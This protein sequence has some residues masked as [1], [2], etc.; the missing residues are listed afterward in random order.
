MIHKRLNRARREVQS[1]SDG[2]DKKPG[3]NH[4]ETN[5]EMPQV[6]AVRRE[7]NKYHLSR[8]E[9]LVALAAAGL[10]GC[11]SSPS[12][13]GGGESKY[14]SK[15][16]SIRYSLNGK[17][18]TVPCGTPIPPGAVCICN[19]VPASSFTKNATCTCD[20]VCVCNTVCTCDTVCSCVSYRP[21]CSCVSYTQSRQICTCDK[22]CTCNLI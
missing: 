3:K 7:G 8:R 14:E 19:C 18:F 13:R 11:A 10:A 15:Y 22:I 6:F 20:K 21:S 1:M 9:F 2:E 17:T 12:P 16:E 4:N 5:E